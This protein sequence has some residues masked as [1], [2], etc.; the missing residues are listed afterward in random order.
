MFNGGRRKCRLFISTMA[1]PLRGNSGGVDPEGLV[2]YVIRS[3]RQI[4]SV[5]SRW[6]MA[7]LLL[8]WQVAQRD[9]VRGEQ[10]MTREVDTARS[11]VNQT[12][13]GGRSSAV[14]QCSFSGGANLGCVDDG[15]QRSC[16]L[17]NDQVVVHLVCTHFFHNTATHTHSR[18]R[19]MN[20]IFHLNKTGQEPLCTCLAM[21]SISSQTQE[22]NAVRSSMSGTTI[23]AQEPN[24]M[25]VAIIT[26]TGMDIQPRARTTGTCLITCSIPITHAGICLPRSRS[27]A[28]GTYTTIWTIVWAVLV[29][30]LQ[31]RMSGMWSTLQTLASK[32]V[33]VHR[34]L[35][36]VSWRVVGLKL[37]VPRR[38][39]VMRNCGIILTLSG[40]TTRRKV[41]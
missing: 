23:L 20:K 10:K 39:V 34:P 36:V 24:L 4:W 1:K 37:L 13:E 25:G 18:R 30:Q 27:V 29:L 22:R 28:R 26:Q 38:R 21:P 11:Q 2:T 33:S 32:T 8:F 17:Y 15:K 14:G 41:Y 31:V 5:N 19:R 16:H 35:V 6:E 7:M 9:V 40:P 12:R 3:S